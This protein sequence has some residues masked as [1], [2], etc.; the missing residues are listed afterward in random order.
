MQP[1]ARLA[2][3]GVFIGDGLAVGAVWIDR[4]PS[5]AAAE[6]LAADPEFAAAQVHLQAAVADGWGLDGDALRADLPTGGEAPDA[7]ALPVT[8][9]G[10]GT[11]CDDATPCP[12]DGFVC[13]SQPGQPGFCTPQ[14]C[15]AGECEAPYVCC[16]DCNPDLA[17]LLP[18][19]GS[20]C[21][22][23]AGTAQLES[24]AGCT[25]G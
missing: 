14:G 19:E 6:A 20:A 24:A 5:Q 18:F 7:P 15:G 1:A 8:P 23:E 22:P 3:E 25:G 2:V 12:D 11:P 17:A 10:T 4:V 9:N 21:F 16:G 13:L